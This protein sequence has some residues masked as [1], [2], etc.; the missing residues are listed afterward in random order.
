MASWEHPVEEEARRDRQ[1]RKQGECIAGVARRGTRARGGLYPSLMRAWNPALSLRN[2]ACPVEDS[3]P[4]WSNSHALT[5]D[6][7]GG[8]HSPGT[9]KCSVEEGGPP[10]TFPETGPP[11]LS[12]SRA[13]TETRFLFPPSPPSAPLPPARVVEKK[14]RKSSR[15]EH[16]QN[17]LIVVCI[18]PWETREDRRW[19]RIDHRRQTGSRACD[20]NFR[21]DVTGSDASNSA[22]W[23]PVADANCRRA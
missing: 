7:R 16:Q 19:W 6:P 9:R 12:R 3:S 5:R 15:R 4:R 20:G 21:I 8:Q 2:T 18:V 11:G 23:Q 14:K 10:Q 13:F 22:A 17:F 1:E